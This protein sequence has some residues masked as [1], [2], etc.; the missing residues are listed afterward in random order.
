MDVVKPLI[1][2]LILNLAVFSAQTRAEALLDQIV[3]P[4][5]FNIQIFAEGVENAR[6]MALGD[7]GTVFVGSRTKGNVYALTDLD[8]DQVADRVLIVDRGL[9]M[10][11]G[12][13]FKDGAL[14]VAAVNRILRYD[15]IEL[16]LGFPP[17]PR[18][19]TSALPD[20]RHHGW[21]YLRF[22]PDGKLYF[23]VGAPCNIC[24]TRGYAQIRRI[25][26]D[27]SD[28]ETFA[29]GVRN[30]VGQA[31]HPVSG[32]L[33]FTDNGRDMMGDDMPSDELNHAPRPG[34]HF[35][36]PF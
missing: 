5:R 31:F 28:I 29:R 34:L 27:G 35:G 32:E 1:C 23:N 30:S 2:L 9:R 19:L 11:S 22:G 15:D 10:P 17:P 13:E 25:N 3:L 26:T 21:K 20:E 33:W 16:R 7:K 12:V 8:G 36:Y 24:E 4:D 6:Q 18:E 14:Y